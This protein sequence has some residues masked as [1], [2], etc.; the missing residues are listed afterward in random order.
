LVAVDDGAGGACVCGIWGCQACRITGPAQEIPL[1]LLLLLLL[2]LLLL[3][4]VGTT[5][6]HH[7]VRQSVL[8]GLHLCLSV[9]V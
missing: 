6:I 3:L 8:D 4:S 1:L 5:G 9:C 2:P 7:S